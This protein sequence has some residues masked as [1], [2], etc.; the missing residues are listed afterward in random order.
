MNDSPRPKRR[1]PS[2][3][4]VGLLLDQVR[5]EEGRSAATLLELY[6]HYLLAIARSKIKDQLRAK[7]S[8]ADVVQE[9]L[10]VALRKF[11][12]ADLRTEEELRHWLR[13]VLH[14][15]LKNHLRKY[16]PG[17]KRDLNREVPLES[18]ESAQWLRQLAARGGLSPR[19]QL[20][21]KETLALVE[22]S[23]DRLP[24]E[25]RTIIYWRSRDQRT[26]VD[27]AQELERKPDAVRM[28]WNRALKALGRVL[29]DGDGRFTGGL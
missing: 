22:Q 6:R 20:K 26:F 7:L 28:L 24:V 4:S 12:A 2:A 11:A 1:R 18:A 5:T 15:K 14:N 8:P 17:T 19:G 25:Y 23:I 10:A 9:A 3:E 21:N 13:R 29:E 27:I 16:A